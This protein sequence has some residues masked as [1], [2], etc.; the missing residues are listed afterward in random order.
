MIVGE[1]TNKV[2]FFDA[3]PEYIED[4]STRLDMIS[5][6]VVEDDRKTWEISHD[7]AGFE[8]MSL[9]CYGNILEYRG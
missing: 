6:N 7:S 9:T 1:L 5:S 8:G 3:I 4:R 2:I